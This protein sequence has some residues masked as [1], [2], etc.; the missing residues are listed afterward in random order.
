ME[1]KAGLAVREILALL[2]ELEARIRESLAVLK[3]LEARLTRK[4][5]RAIN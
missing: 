4:P 5:G 1:S 2:D 3:K